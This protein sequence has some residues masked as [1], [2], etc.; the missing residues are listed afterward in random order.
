M[1]AAIAK[2]GKRTKKAQKA[3]RRAAR[4]KNYVYREPMAARLRRFA[5]AGVFYT[6]ATLAAAALAGAVAFFYFYDH[7]EEIVEQRVRSGF[8]HTRAGIYAAPFVLRVN[9]KTSPENV[10][11]LLRR[12]GYVEGRTEDDIFNGSFSVLGGNLIEI[13]TKN[14]SNFQTET[15]RVRFSG[16]RI[17]A[18]KDGEA[19]PLEVY[20]IGPELL[21]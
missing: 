2:F 8:W 6:S 1:A 11:E 7:Y 19:R 21:T 12:A 14:Y 9:Q 4:V 10:V 16:R 18:I 13:R 15:A 5:R 20:R 3:D 17:A